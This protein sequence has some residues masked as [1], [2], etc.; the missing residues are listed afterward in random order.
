MH[1]AT[2][3]CA[4]RDDPQRY[5]IPRHQ[6]PELAEVSDLVELDL[7][8]E[9]VRPT[10]FRLYSERVIHGEIYKARPE[11]NA[12]CHHHAHAVLPFCHIGPGDGAGVPPRLP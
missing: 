2:S 3:A 11:V 5:F 1:S 8:S 12:V 10:E 6:A 9:P 7:D 4:I